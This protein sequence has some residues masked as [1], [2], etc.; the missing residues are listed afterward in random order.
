MEY[1]RLR[2]EEGV[3]GEMEVRSFWP[4]QRTLEPT[5]E[6]WRRRRGK[7][8]GGPAN[9]ESSHVS[10]TR[11][12]FRSFPPPRASVSDEARR[13]GTYRRSHLTFLPASDTCMAECL[14]ML[15]NS[16][17]CC[18]CFFLTSYP[19]L[20]M[21]CCPALLSELPAS[22]P[23][24]IVCNFHTPHPPRFAPPSRSVDIFPARAQICHNTTPSPAV[25]RHLGAAS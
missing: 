5:N 16:S 12:A 21:C 10:P 13:E 6:A 23:D 11:P 15:L 7:D 17:G 24:R 4:V 22:F 18:R 20:C 9:P 2:R 14:V 19:Q 25:Y 3:V 8:L 1:G